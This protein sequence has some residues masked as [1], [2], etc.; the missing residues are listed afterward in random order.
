MCLNI[1]KHFFPRW[2]QWKSV[3]K[4]FRESKDVEIICAEDS[5]IPILVSKLIV[6]QLY[7]LW[8]KLLLLS[9]FLQ[10]YK[11]WAKNYFYIV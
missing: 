7:I 11:N 6:G 2:K 8:A 3:E 1:Y 4:D 5:K 10:F 9:V